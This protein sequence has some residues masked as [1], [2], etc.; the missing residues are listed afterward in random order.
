[1]TVEGQRYQP[2]TAAAVSGAVIEE[3]EEESLYSMEAAVDATPK[4]L[5][6]NNKLAMALYDWWETRRKKNDAI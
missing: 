6:N 3:E 5:P 2:S 4:Q 1:M